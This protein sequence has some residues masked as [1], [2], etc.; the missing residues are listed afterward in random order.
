[1]NWNSFWVWPL[2]WKK[3]EAKRRQK[4]YKCG[5]IV[6]PPRKCIGWL[7][8]FYFVHDPSPISF[9]PGRRTQG[10]MMSVYALWA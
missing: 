10:T 3:K 6:A 5:T 4:A 9:F 8:I 7:L 1:M 2:S